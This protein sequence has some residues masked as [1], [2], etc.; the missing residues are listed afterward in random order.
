MEFKNK[1]V[2]TF[3]SIHLVK[4]PFKHPTDVDVMVWIRIICVG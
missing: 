1:V 2:K 4:V 3:S